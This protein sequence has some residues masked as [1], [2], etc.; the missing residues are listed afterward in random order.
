M[1]LPGGW[2][3]VAI[4]VVVLVLFGGK[5]IPEL[6]KGIG[7]GIKDF[8]QA[9]KEDEAED[10]KEIASSTKEKESITAETKKEN[11]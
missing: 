8:K 4:V 5:K 10:K 6:A 2:E 9:V 11:A 3:L 1:G 7:R